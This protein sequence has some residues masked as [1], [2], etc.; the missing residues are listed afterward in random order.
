MTEKRKSLAVLTLL[1]KEEPEGLEEDDDDNEVQAVKVDKTKAKVETTIAVK[2]PRTEKQIAVFERAKATA[3]TNADNRRIVAEM[4]AKEERELLDKKIV[5]KAIA[6][7]KKEIKKQAILDAVSDDDTPI[8]EIR[9]I[10]SLPAKKSLI[11]EIVL[12]P[13]VEKPKYIFI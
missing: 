1:T 12:P 7:K 4:R 10:V 6:I 8:E 2:K 3:K 13:A 9:K 5:L 11:K